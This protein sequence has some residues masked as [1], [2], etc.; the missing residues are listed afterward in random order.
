[1]RITSR[2]ARPVWLRKTRSRVRFVGCGEYSDETH[3]LSR[4]RWSVRVVGIRHV[5]FRVRMAWP[6]RTR[7]VNVRDCA[8]PESGSGGE[9][10]VAMVKSADLRNRAHLA[11]I[12]RLDG[13]SIRAVFI[14]RQMG[15]SV[16]IVV[17]TE[18]SENSEKSGVLRLPALMSPACVSPSSDLS[19]RLLP[20]D[21]V[22]GQLLN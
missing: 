1:M 8:V 6:C 17:A 12:R 14:E 3:E 9:A 19:S 4:S 15:A 13:T 20:A 18:N 2:R 21:S 16:V 22:V 10:F 5:D 7:G 11:A